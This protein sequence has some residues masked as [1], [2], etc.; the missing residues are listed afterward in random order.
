[1]VNNCKPA[2]ILHLANTTL[3]SVEVNHLCVPMVLVIVDVK[4]IVMALNG[5]CVDNTW[6]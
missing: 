5:A 4:G 3:N 1:M 6:E 2:L